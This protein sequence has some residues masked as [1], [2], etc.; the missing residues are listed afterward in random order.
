MGKKIVTLGEIMLRLSTVD[1]KRIIQS[2]LFQAD[3]GGGEANVAISLSNFGIESSFITKLPE[4]FLGDSVLRY[5]KANQVNI[6]HIILGG[7]RLGTYYLEVGN[8]IRNSSV[9]YDRKYSS[10][11]TLTYEELNIEKILK[12]AYIL[13]LSGI[14]PALSES[15]KDLTLKIIKKA[16]EMGVLVSFD[17]NFRGKLWSVE[18]AGKTFKEYLPYIDICFAG[19]LDG[20][21]IL[22]LDI[23]EEK[24]S[25]FSEILKAYYK[26]INDFYPN[27]KYF[28]STKREIHSVD[29]NSLEGFIYSKGCIYNSKK[30]RFSIVDRVGGGDAFAAGALYGI[31]QD[32]N[33]ED[34]VEFATGA[35]VIKHTIRGDANLVSVKE[36]DNFIKNGAG[37]I[38][39]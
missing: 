14:I 33:I 36:V 2:N 28:I 22:K 39:R 25:S 12:D 13:H 10:F 35:S 3:Y 7:E 37:K 17:F 6:D 34:I 1:N 15:C 29:D 16:K 21:Y 31:I 18:E 19:I 27:I 4:N 20:K 30:Y 11:S 24:Y 26:K 9:I 5:L 8:G 32:M 38:S 23:D